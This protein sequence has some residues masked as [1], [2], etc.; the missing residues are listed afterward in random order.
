[1]NQMLAG[2]FFSVVGISA[3]AAWWAF[4][5]WGAALVLGYGAYCLLKNLE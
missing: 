1:M 4:G 2:V 3:L 5:G